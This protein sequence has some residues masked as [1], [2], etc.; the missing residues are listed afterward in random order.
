[1]TDEKIMI[2]EKFSVKILSIGKFLELN[3]TIFI[4]LASEKNLFILIKNF[5]FT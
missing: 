4:G 3:N 1:M 2:P 5:Y